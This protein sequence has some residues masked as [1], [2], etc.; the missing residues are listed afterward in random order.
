MSFSHHLSFDC[1]NRK[2]HKESLQKGNKVSF[3]IGK[4]FDKK[5]NTESEIAIN[6]KLM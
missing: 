5:K 4:G 3:F 1:T 2:K 6:I